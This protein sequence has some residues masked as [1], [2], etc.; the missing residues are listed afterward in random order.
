MIHICSVFIH[1][2]MAYKR[3]SY[4]TSV[5]MSTFLT[6]LKGHIDT[7][8][9]IHC[10]IQ[11]FEDSYL[12]DMEKA[13]V[14]CFLAE[15]Y[16]YLRHSSLSISPPEFVRGL[17]KCVL[18]RINASSSSLLADVH[19]AVSLFIHTQLCKL[20]MEEARCV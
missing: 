1:D 17:W 19:T 14:C 16:H 2:A 8:A 15:G 7:D 6:A 5:Q 11:R 10:E 4:S 12:A 20:V 18:G 3:Q 13:I 9:F